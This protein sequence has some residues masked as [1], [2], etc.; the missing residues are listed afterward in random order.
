PTVTDETVAQKGTASYPIPTMTT[1]GAAQTLTMDTTGLPAGVTAAFTPASV[2]SGT[3]AM[4]TL[5]ADATAPLGPTHYTISATSPT[6][7]VTTDV[8]LTITA[9][10]APDAGNGNGS[11][12][13]GSQSGGCCEASNQGS[14]LGSI[15]IAGAV[16]GFGLRRRRRT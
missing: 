6:N 16:L 9:P 15:L 8:A 4:I 5:T 1:A 3:S 11:D 10:Q 12:G 13:N 14:P 2:Q 7:F